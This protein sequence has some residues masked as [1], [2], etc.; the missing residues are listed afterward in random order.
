MDMEYKEI[1]E[2]AQNA[3]KNY[4]VKLDVT[5]RMNG[6]LS[7]TLGRVKYFQNHLG[8]KVEVIEFSTKYFSDPNRNQEVK[9]QVVL[10]EIAHYLA[11]LT[12]YQSHQHDEVFRDCCAK[13]DCTTTG[14]NATDESDKLIENIQVKYK[15]DCRCSACGNHI[16]YYKRY[17]RTVENKVSG[18][19]RA[20][21]DMIQLY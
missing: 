20:K 6:R 17:P 16:R 10:H 3:C 2:I 1:L 13:I 12:D 15:Y 5:V 8:V 11:Y 18:C 9:R 4:G 21:I 14:E 7:R 19:C